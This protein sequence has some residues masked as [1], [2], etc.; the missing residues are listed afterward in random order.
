MW[1]QIDR[2]HNGMDI[3]N[4]NCTDHR[5]TKTFLPIASVLLSFASIRFVLF[6]LAAFEFEFV[7]HRK[8]TR[9]AVKNV[10]LLVNKQA[11][12][13]SLLCARGDDT[14]DL[15]CSICSLPILNSTKFWTKY[16]SYDSSATVSSNWD[17]KTYAT[18]T[19]TWIIITPMGLQTP[20]KNTKNL[21]HIL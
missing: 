16:Y 9:L 15:N 5:W 18:R 20:K 21:F 1:N 6:C 8:N 12:L 19:D 7:E 14:I 17:H 3:I 2:D 11:V 4:I 13:F 10:F